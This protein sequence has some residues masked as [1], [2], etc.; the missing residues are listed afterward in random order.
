MLGAAAGSEMFARAAAHCYALAGE[1]D[2]AIDWLERTVEM[3]MWNLAFLET[4]DRFLEPLR[5]DPRFAGVLER[6]RTLRQSLRSIQT[7]TD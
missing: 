5:G 6:V 3:G 7:S 2:E 4:H 1:V